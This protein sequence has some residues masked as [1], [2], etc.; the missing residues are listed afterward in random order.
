MKGSAFFIASNLT[1][2]MEARLARVSKNLAQW[3]VAQKAGVAQWA[4][5]AYERGDRYV[6]PSWVAQIREAL[7]LEPAA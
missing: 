3:E 6:P 7:G 4:V 5:S 2:G 1:E